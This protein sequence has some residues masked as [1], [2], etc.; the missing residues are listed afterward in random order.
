MALRDIS[1]IG[2]DDDKRWVDLK[3]TSPVFSRP[4]VWAMLHNHML[5]QSIA[6]AMAALV[7]TLWL[8]ASDRMRKRLY[9][10]LLIVLV[11][12]VAIIL[13]AAW[14][15]GES[16][17]Q[18]GVAV[19]VV[20][21]IPTTQ[22]AN[23]STQPVTW[24]NTPTRIETQFPPLELHVIMAGVFTAVALV[25][26]GLSFRRINGLQA[27]LEP[28][29]IVTGD[30]A[31]A[32]QSQPTPATAFD[33]G[34]TFNPN[35]EVEI[36]PFAPAGRFWMLAFLL[37]FFTVF[38]GLWVIARGADVF[39]KM[40]GHPRQLPRLLWEQIRPSTGEMMNRHLAHGIAGSRDCFVTHYSGTSGPLRA[41]RADHLKL[42][43]RA[44][45]RRPRRAGLAGRAAAV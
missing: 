25:A 2:I 10:P 30:P 3:A 42:D 23:P 18:N 9:Y 1:R 11:W 21:P 45:D 16:V 32:M 7:V 27:F 24:L 14:F 40:D 26:I 33:V 12:T 43:D 5:Y 34:R 17:Y 35:L 44:A 8:G 37:A 41:A 28:P 4:E 22:A 39:T 31:T 6:T 19:A 36:K 20:F 38:G 13:R 15:G 29:P